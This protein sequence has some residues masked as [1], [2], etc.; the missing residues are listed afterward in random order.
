[1]GKLIFFVDDDKM[2]INLL[3]YTFQSRQHFNVKSFLSGE[4]CVASMDLNPDIIVLDHNMSGSG[5]SQMDGLETLEKIR[6]INKEVP[7]IVLT[8]YGSEELL[9]RFMN[10]GAKRFLTKDDYFIDHLIETISQVL[11]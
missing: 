3:E 8:G 4:D 10:K 1:M 11:N 6:E 7:I 5:E 9:T 2:I